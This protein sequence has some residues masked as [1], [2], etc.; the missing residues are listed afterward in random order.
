MIDQ[1]KC[2]FADNGTTVAVAKACPWNEVR[3]ELEYWTDEEGNFI[4]N[5]WGDKAVKHYYQDSDGG[6]Y[7]DENG[8]RILIPIDAYGSD[9]KDPDFLNHYMEGWYVHGYLEEPEP[10]EEELAALEEEN[11]ENASEEDAETASEESS[12]GKPAEN[13]QP[14]SE[15]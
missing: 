2:L 3:P 10:T 9:I 7:L 1:D 4:Y 13:A 15:G 8:E 5:K 11:G 12:E 6:Y 14:S